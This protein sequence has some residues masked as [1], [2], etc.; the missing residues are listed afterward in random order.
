MINS[1]PSDLCETIDMTF[2]VI[3]YYLVKEKLQYFSLIIKSLF[4]IFIQ[5]SPYKVGED[6]LK[7]GNDHQALFN[8]SGPFQNMDTFTI[9][10]IVFSTLKQI[11]KILQ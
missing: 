5:T 2:L 9:H 11:V 6:N 10:E 4:F 1:K 8:W 3:N 7:Y